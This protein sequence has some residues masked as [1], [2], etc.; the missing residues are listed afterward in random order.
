MYSEKY[1]EHYHSINDGAFSESLE[2]HV[3]PAFN[4]IKKQNLKV[5]N[6]LDICFGLGYN[7]LTSIYY[8]HKEGLDIK[9]N[10]YSPEL[11]EALISSLKNYTYPKEFDDYK[12]IIISLSK[13]NYYKNK[14]KNIEISIEIIDACEYYKKINTPIDIIFQDAFSLKKNPSLWSEE[15]FA[16]LKKISSENVILTTYTKTPIVR[17]SLSKNDFF[18]YEHKGENV[19]KSMVCFLKEQSDLKVPLKN[20]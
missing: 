5:V 15:F 8:A 17:E 11:D 4:H 1:Q 2:K 20:I 9:L 10:V 12:D 3:K 6:I 7:T 13:N 14:N 19:R 18:L 16:S